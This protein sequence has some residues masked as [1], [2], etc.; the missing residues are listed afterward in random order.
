MHAV[1]PLASHFQNCM[2]GLFSVSVSTMS[3]LTEAFPELR[4]VH[5]DEIMADMDR[6]KDNYVT[7]EEYVGECVKCS[8]P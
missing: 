1:V 4:D 5:V 6:N 8:D 7:L 3:L 2:L